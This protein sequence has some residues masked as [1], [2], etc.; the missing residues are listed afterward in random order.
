MSEVAIGRQAASSP[1]RLLTVAVL[2]AV[3]IAAFIAMLI[4][5]AYAPDMRSGRN[6]GTHA[7][8]NGATGFRALYELAEATGHKPRIVRNQHE[9][10]TEDLLVV[11]PDRGATDISAALIARTAKPTLFILPKWDT[12]NDASH[13]GWVR[14][15]GLIDVSEPAGVLAPGVNFTIRRYR[16][17]GSPLRTSGLPR[18]IHFAA[19]RTIQAIAGV[20]LGKNQ[21]KDVLP[22]RPLVSDARGGILL[23]QLGNQ[24]LFVL[25][26]PDLFSNFGLR[27]PAQAAAALATLDWLNSTE[28]EGIAFDVSFNGLGHS[29]SPL[30]LL[31]EPP[32]V[33]LTIGIA[34]ALLLT[35]WHAFARFG[36]PLPAVRA[37]AFGKAALVD[38]SAALMR[39]ARRESH[40]GGRYAAVIRDRAARAF[41]APARL[42]GDALDAYL[43]ALKRP[44]RFTDLR[45]RAEDAR[46]R[47]E[48][49]HAARA[50]HAWQADK[51]GQAEKMEKKP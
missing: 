4:L 29:N 18:A 5:G 11:S 38:N 24:N 13:P 36:A 8:S 21:S 48:M 2:I 35:G 32:F 39:K 46:D 51:S 10:D 6:G 17:D 15:F 50:L 3:G 19:P 26:D 20:T 43:D 22:L 16:S 49:L 1:F 37:I 33:A 45:Q 9:F 28:A 41:G 25:A 12:A 27:D 34:A 30:K 7:L 31:L 40:M 44:Q 42:Q 47:I 23:A 14:G